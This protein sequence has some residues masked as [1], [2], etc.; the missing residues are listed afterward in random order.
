M[1]SLRLFFLLAA[2][3]A[4]A[5][6]DPM[7]FP[8]GEELPDDGFLTLEAGAGY[9]TDET[10]RYIKAPL[11]FTGASSYREIS[12]RIV[13]LSDMV[14]AS[15]YFSGNSSFL[16]ATGLYLYNFG[17]VDIDYLSWHG[18]KWSIGLGAGLAHQGFLFS[19]A[20]KSAHAVV[21]RLR[22]QAFVYW[23]D[24]I[25]TQG[26]LT[27]PV[28]LYQSATDNFLILN[29]ELNTLFDFVGRVRHPQPG[30]Y[31]F[32][33]SLQYDFIRVNFAERHFI[34]HEF[35]PAFKAM[36]VY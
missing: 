22:A 14:H 29:A 36:V 19:R 30:S 24:Y 11:F 5:A 21:L 33:L 1:K 34:Q 32:S 20:P 28:A 35:T 4:A 16:G 15:E 10:A 9:N 26:V 23:W 7:M 8:S 25:A 3:A 18:R 6:E 17:L 12:T 27:L 31:M 13:L 2:F